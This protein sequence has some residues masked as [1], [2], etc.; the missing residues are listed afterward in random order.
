MLGAAMDLAAEFQAIG[1]AFSEHQAG[2]TFTCRRRYGGSR[3]RESATGSADDFLQEILSVLEDALSP[4]CFADAQEA[5]MGE[6][7]EE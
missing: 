3:S 7:G 1:S 2:S 4:D 5:L 6:F